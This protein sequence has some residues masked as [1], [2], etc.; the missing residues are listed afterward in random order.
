MQWTGK[1]HGFTP[2]LKQ[3]L[4]EF[5]ILHERDFWESPQRFEDAA[6]YEKP[7]VAVDQSLACGADVIAKFEYSKCKFLTVDSLFESTANTFGIVHRVA[8]LVGRAYVH[9]IINVKKKKDITCS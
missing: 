4:R 3:R 2:S 6:S 8:D 7:L 5:K 1:H 9:P